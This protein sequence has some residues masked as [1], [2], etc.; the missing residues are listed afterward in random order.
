MYFTTQYIKHDFTSTFIM[1][2][3]IYSTAPA[4]V[5]FNFCLVGRRGPHRRDRS[6]LWGKDP[7]APPEA[8]S[9]VGS[10]AKLQAPSAPGL[11]A[12]G[13]PFPRR[14]CGSN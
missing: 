4:K 10:H 5:S 2:T 7:C 1:E 6:E 9:A 3:E 12:A 13:Q 8:N 14:T 11:I